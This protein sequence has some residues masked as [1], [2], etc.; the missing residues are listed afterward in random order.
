MLAS[1]I[2]KL[3]WSYR[4]NRPDMVG[5]VGRQY[6]A[7][8]LAKNPPPLRDEIPVFVF[9]SVEPVSFEAQLQYLQLNRYT[10]VTGDDLL[11]MLRGERPI[12]ERAVALTF[13][14]GTASLYSVAYPLLKRYGF[15]GISFLIP[16]CIPDTVPV[17]P[18]VEQ[19]AS[20]KASLQELLRREHGDYPLC[21]WEEIREMHDSGTIDFEAHTMY[22]HLIHVSPELVDFINPGFDFYFYANVHV[23]L[24][25]ENGVPNFRRQVAYGTP[26]YRNEPRLSGRRQYFDNEPVRQACAEFVAQQGG[27]AFFA[28]KDW[29]QELA[30]FHKQQVQQFGDGGYETPEQMRQAIR[31][32]LAQCK[33]EIEARLRGKTVRHFCFPWFI[34][35]PV[36]EQLAV[37]VGYE[38]L[39]WGMLSGVR[40]NRK[41]G[42]PRRIVRLED[43]YIYRLPGEGRKKL[44]EIIKEQVAANV[45]RLG[46]VGWIA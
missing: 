44:A 33:Q 21:S 14:D 24:Y 7:F 40:S 42:D 15:H 11:A 38:A 3:R 9:H 31:E 2:N 10:T 19:V 13:D 36:A 20:G 27:E 34:G 4:K 18:T 26:V 30:A 17:Q 23:P 16:G 8:I 32:D 37:E 5:L 41:G 28:R 39:Y 12:P 46:C 45:P 29:R 35:A 6:P 22:H 1:R 25:Y 43:R